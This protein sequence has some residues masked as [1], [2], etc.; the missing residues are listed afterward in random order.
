MTDMNAGR[1]TV[2][3]WAY[4][5]NSSGIEYLFGHTA[6]PW[7]NR[8]QIYLD[9]GNLCIGLGSSHITRTNITALMTQTWH[10][11]A[12]TWDGTSYDIYVDAVSEATGTYSGLTRLSTLADIGNNGNPEER[13]EG[14]NG[15]IDEVRIYDRAL[16][17]NE[18]A[19]LGPPF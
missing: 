7:S 10:H 14:F 16:T 11:I 8:I 9:N 15:L 2:S 13:N 1:G 18:I 4:P 6:D 19:N 3:L 17:A 5:T 12:L